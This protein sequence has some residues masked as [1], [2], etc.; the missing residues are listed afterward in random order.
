MFFFVLSRAWDKE[1][2][3][4]SHEKSNLKLSDSALRCST[5][6]TQRLFVGRGPLRSSYMISVLHT[7]TIRVAKV[8]KQGNNRLTIVQQ[9]VSL[10]N[11]FHQEKIMVSLF[12]L[13]FNLKFKCYRKRSDQFSRVTCHE[14][15]F[16]RKFRGKFVTGKLKKSCAQRKSSR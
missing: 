16:V 8:N 4:S 10:I 14:Q 2:I 11:C 7:A 5:T 6:E 13:V 1:K 12:P 9:I 15:I 3:P